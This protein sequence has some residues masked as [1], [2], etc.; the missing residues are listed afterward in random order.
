[1]L[2]ASMAG[3]V[4]MRSAANQRLA[5]ALSSE[6]TQSLARDAIHDRLR[7][8]VADQM[9]A[10]EPRR[11]RPL[12]NSTRFEMQQ[13]GLNWSVRIQDTQGLIDLYMTNPAILNAGLIASAGF[14]GKRDDALSG[15]PPGER[16]APLP[17]SVARFGISPTEK[18]LVT[19]SNSDSMIRLDTA[20]SDL[21]RRLGNLSPHLVTGGQVNKVR[22]DIQAAVT[23]SIVSGLAP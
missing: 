16:F 21:R 22:I 20:P 13:G 18:N 14:I 1:M 9:V 8:M 11:D 3:W 23:I 19:Q 6:L 5:A 4:Q 7:G 15:L 17:M 12:F 10:T 2:L